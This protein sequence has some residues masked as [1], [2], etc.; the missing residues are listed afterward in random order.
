MTDVRTFLAHRRRAA[1]LSVTALAERVGISRQALAAIEAGRSTPST[2]VALL[3]ARALDCRVEDLFALARAPLPELPRLAPGSRVVLGRVDGRWVAEPLEPRSTAPADGLV[4]DDGR[5]EPLQDPDRLEGNLLVSG[6]APVLGALAGHLDRAPDGGARWLH[7]TSVEALTALATGRAHV[8]GLHLAAAHAPEAHDALIRERLGPVPV[9]VVTLVLWREGLAMAPGNPLGLRGVADLGRSG[10]RVARRPDGA[11]AT[12]AL[13]AALAGVGL[14][15]ADL[16][17]PRVASHEDAAAAVLHGAAD[18]AVVV[19]PVAEAWGLSFLPLLEE[20]FELVLRADQRSHP[21][22]G[23]LLDQLA[24]DRFAREVRGMG[25]YDT[26]PMGA[27][28]RLE[29]A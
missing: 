14:D 16:R 22:V 19:E 20:R 1:G 24:S 9:D 6:C 18:A 17:G 7:R 12:R 4:D 15:V 28:R 23:R 26:R 21:G 10:L 5:V 27:L 29:A 2:S 11:G 3:L 13:A 25:A 8:A